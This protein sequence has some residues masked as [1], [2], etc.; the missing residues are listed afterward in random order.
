M[1]AM[2][3]IGMGPRKAG[4]GKTSPA[5][6]SEKSMPKEGLVRLPM[7]MLEMDGGEGEMTPPEAGDSVELTGTVEK[8]DGDTVFVRINDAMAEAE[9]MAEV[10]EES[11]IS[12]EDKMR[13]LAEEADEESYS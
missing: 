11:E 6:S 5:S 10:E 7:S 9:P 1:G 13:K 2:L 8:V 4:E 12:E 3:V